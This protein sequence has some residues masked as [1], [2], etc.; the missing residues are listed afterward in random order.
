[1]L[2]IYGF[3]LELIKRLRV[4]IGVIERKDRDVGR[5]LRRC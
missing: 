5:Q 3:V 4:S 1:M 2:K